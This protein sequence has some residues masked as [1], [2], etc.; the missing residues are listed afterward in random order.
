MGIKRISRGGLCL[1]L[2]TAGVPVVEAAT[3]STKMAVSATV[4]YQCAV[5]AAPLDFGVAPIGGISDKNA[6]VTITVTCSD[7]L[8]YNVALD[9]GRNYTGSGF[10]K[11][12]NSDGGVMLYL[13]RKPDSAATWGDSDVSPGN[14]YPSGTSVSGVGTGSEQVLSAFATA[15]SNSAAFDSSQVGDGAFSDSV[16]VTV[17]Y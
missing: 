1:A 10:R 6:V 4:D 14:T 12:L 5:S 8:P 16:L 13:V 3:T 11:M 2:C 9:G 15:Y 7:G 17:H